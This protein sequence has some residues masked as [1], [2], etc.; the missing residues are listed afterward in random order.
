MLNQIKIKINTEILM[1]IKTLGKTG[2]RV[3]ELCLGTMTFG[4][5]RAWGTSKEESFK[6]ME[7]FSANGGNFLDTAN[8]YTDGTSEKIVGEFIAKEREKY[9]V[10]TKYT[11]T[12]NPNDPNASGSHRKNLVQSVEAS[13]KRLGTDYID[14]YYIHRYDPFTPIEEVMRGLDDLV[15][16]GKIIYPAISDMQA[17]LVSRANTLS[18]ERNWSEFTAL[19]I[20][21]SLLERTPERDLI[22]MAEYYKM[23]VLAWS[24]LAGGVLTGK[25]NLKQTDETSRHIASPFR[26]IDERSLAI[27]E[28]V[29]QVAEKIGRRPASVAIRWMMDKYQFVIPIIGAKSLEQQVQN[30]EVLEFNLSNEDISEL[31]AVSQVDMGFPNTFLEKTKSML[32]GNTNIESMF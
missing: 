25:Y 3:S 10:A 7:N 11:F 32:I 17:W 20:E 23:P 24:P 5:E 2:L 30:M 21:Y 16:A 29:M 6:I 19:Q 1:K 28:K 31:D 9:V 12:M 26:N 13:L 15:R 4:P 22:P 14:L 18:V 8:L 27:T